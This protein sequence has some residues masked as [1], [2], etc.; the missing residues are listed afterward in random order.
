MIRVT[1]IHTHYWG[2]DELEGL[3]RAAQEVI[4]DGESRMP[5]VDDDA[6]DAM[7]HRVRLLETA[8][9]LLGDRAT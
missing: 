2:D 9:R 6:R 5:F 7:M 3:R 8:I 1:R 4:A